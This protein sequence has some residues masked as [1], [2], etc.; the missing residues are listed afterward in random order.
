M[1]WAAAPMVIP[2]TPS[3]AIPLLVLAGAL[4][5]SP[6]EASKAHR[7]EPNRYVITE[8]L[9][10]VTPPGSGRAGPEFLYFEQSARR[11]P[12]FLGTCAPT[13]ARFAAH[14]RGTKVVARFPAGS[15]PGI[16][17]SLRV[18]GVIVD[19]CSR[20]EGTL[21]VRGRAK[22]SPLRAVASTCGDGVTDP[23]FEEECD[24][25]GSE[26]FGGPACTASCECPGPSTSLVLD[27]EPGD[28]IGSGATRAFAP[29][30][31]TFSVRRNSANGVTVSFDGVENWYLDFSAP[32]AATLIPGPYERATRYPFHSPAGP[33]LAISGDAR[34]CNTLTGR[35]DVLEAVFDPGGQVLSFAA[36]FE[37][38]CEGKGPALFGRIL[39]H[40]SGPPFPPPPDTDADGVLDTLDNC[41]AAAN[42]GQDDG[43][44]DGIGDVCDPEFARTSIF[45]DSDA[46]DY[47]G[48][49]L[50]W[51]VTPVD[52]TFAVERNSAN[53]VTV[54]FAGVDHWYLDFSAPRAET[55]IPGPYEAATRFPFN[56]P[57]APGLDVYGA[58][59]GCNDLTGRFDVLEAV[60]GPGG[61]VLS[62]A[63]DFEQHCEGGTPALTGRILFHAS[64]PPF[65]PPPDTDADGVLDTLDNCPTAAN[66][67]QD[68]A[69]SDG[70][71]DA[72]DLEF[73]NTSVLFDS[74][75]GDYIGQG[76][77]WTLTP[78]DATF[79]LGRN[80]ANGVSA[81]ILGADP[82]WLDFSAPR[83]AMLVP[84]P[85]EAAARF[86]F[87]SP[88]GAG[89]DV[90]GAAR[91]CNRLTG[92]FDVLEAVFGPGGQVL[93]FAADFEQHCEGG[94]P[95][96]TGRIL[97]NASGPPFPPPPDTDAD[98][99]LDTLD[100]CPTAA[101][102]GQDDADWDG[103][104]DACDPEF[105]NTSLVLDS[106][107]GDYIG[108]G[109][110]LTLRPADG[111][112]TVERQIDNCVSVSFHG[113][114]WW[115]LDFCAPDA[116]T[117]IPGPYEGATRFP[118]QEPTEPG[119]SIAGASRGCNQLTG[120]FDVLEAVFGPGTEVQRFAADFEQHCEGLP[121]ALTGRILFNASGPPF[122][123]P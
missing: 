18:R 65:P 43:D 76:R 39:F 56:S 89:L 29:Q 110:G 2:I 63:A 109:L 86:P 123:P 42:P 79:T 58:G 91:G 118:F 24:P 116:G 12:L 34:G 105:T 28:F 38:H 15:C 54:S 32:H 66:P 102:P 92:R 20:F 17:G 69:D 25:Q 111:T 70:L 64:G 84:G 35:F 19:E 77:T 93:S 22:K 96:L 106:E 100:N 114:D 85:Y 1:D 108:G 71:G 81:F 41:Q 113:E 53:G 57:T 36:D 51:T 23:G 97:F 68:D 67:G 103:L 5:A 112:F 14:R 45:V 60:F 40:A 50:T 99:V 78:A 94:T 98:G 119:L 16:E 8:P 95:A 90:S 7:C 72:C 27:S 104:G 115:M 48:Q 87:N 46:G 88:T 47:I 4:L 6:V 55:L 80:S 73:E 9:P 52:G 122:A 10:V 11:A 117:L 37:Q 21:E 82:W 101:N 49:G 75:A 13:V 120:R 26:C 61:E 30:D 44:V 83:A 31:G 33:G 62:F 59:R 3:S 107:P 121:P 74:D